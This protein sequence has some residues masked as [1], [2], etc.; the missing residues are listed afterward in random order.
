MVPGTLAVDAGGAL[1][2]LGHLD[3]IDLIWF[4]TLGAIL[5]GE[6]GWASG[7]WLGRRGV[8]PGRGLARAQTLF[9]RYGGVAL[10]LGRFLGPVAGFVPLAAALA[11]MERRRFVLWNVLGGVL[12]ALTHVSLGYLA[13]DVLARIGPYLPR[14]VLPLALLAALVALTWIAT[15]SLRRGVP[16]IRRGV[17][18]ALHKAAGWH[19]VARLGERHPRVARFLVAR[20][21]PARGR[22]LLATAITVLVV[23]LVALFIDGAFDLAMVP[24]TVALDQR[25]AQLAHAYWSPGALGFAG[26]FTQAGHVPVATLVALAC[27]LGFAAAGR[28]AAAAGMAVAVVGNAVTVTLL[29]LVFGRARPEL[30]YFLETSHSFPSGH[31]AISVALYGTLALMLWRERVIGPTTAVVAGVGMASGLGFTRV[32]LVEHFLSDVLNGWV[33][34]AI[35]MVIGFALAEGFRHRWA[36]H[37]P[38]W[39]RAGL[40]AMAACLIAAGGFALR[41]VKDPVARGAVAETVIRDLRARV[42]SGQFPVEVVRLDGEALPPVSL[43]T[44]GLRQEA[45]VKRLEA[46]GWVRVPRPDFWSVAAA[47]RAELT[48]TAQPGAAVPPA[49]RAAVPAAVALRAPEGVL[50]VWPAGVDDIGQPMMAL[51][52]ASEDGARGWSLTE[53]RR[54]V[55]SAIGGTAQ[56]IPGPAAKG[57]RWSFDGQ[58]LRLEVGGGV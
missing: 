8:P 4:V 6:I 49:F 43:V 25:V 33:V 37:G 48:Q 24:D 57:R 36:L 44:V 14:P 19:W 46:V 34:G 5:G 18:A 20:L 13:G 11:G 2:R 26:W 15:R 42:A 1:V 30:S 3:F 12:F 31:A 39:R 41:D 54:A 58:I 9:T 38:L 29:K 16:V 53:A 45:L 51:A 52:I 23:Y 27:V 40:A 47:L 10:V 7:K 22:G 56:T 32:Y 55:M 21:D 28:R 50:R 17:G 35:W